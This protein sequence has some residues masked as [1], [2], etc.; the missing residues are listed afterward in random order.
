MKLTDAPEEIRKGYQHMMRRINQLIFYM[1]VWCSSRCSGIRS[2]A[3]FCCSLSVV[4]RSLSCC[5]V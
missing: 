2:L 5:C 3:Q 4:S 1:F